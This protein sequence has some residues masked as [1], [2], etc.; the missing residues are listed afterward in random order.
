M[1]TPKKVYIGDGVYA[2]DDGMHIVLETR[3]SGDR[4]PTL[5]MVYLEPEVISE[6][7]AFIERARGLTITAVRA[8]RGTS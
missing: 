1:S 4:H 5:D 7:M 3:R 6:L 2:W 8:V